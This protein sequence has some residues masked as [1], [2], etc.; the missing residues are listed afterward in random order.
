M[1]IIASVIA[2]EWR[3]QAG[4]VQSESARPRV[5]SLQRA[6]EFAPFRVSEGQLSAR[7][8]IAD[9][10]LSVSLIFNPLIDT[11]DDAQASTALAFVRVAP[12]DEST[13]GLCDS[14]ACWMPVCHSQHP[15][16]PTALNPMMQIE[17]A[18][19]GRWYD[20]YQDGWWFNG[21]DYRRFSLARASRCPSTCSIL[22]MLVASHR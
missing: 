4:D 5:L 9:E 11:V 1:P 2:D 3:A 16:A 6:A 21:P 12:A 15:D 14:L 19:G 13:S 18:G 10:A 7:S 20:V 22:S 17:G 8:A